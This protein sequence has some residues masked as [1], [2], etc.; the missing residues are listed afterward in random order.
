MRW[1]DVA[2]EVAAEVFAGHDL[3]SEQLAAVATGVRAVA[4]TRGELTREALVNAAWQFRSPV[5]A[6]RG[7]VTGAA[8]FAAGLDRLA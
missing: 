4:A 6:T 7:I 8:D 3:T 1:E 5:D 2:L